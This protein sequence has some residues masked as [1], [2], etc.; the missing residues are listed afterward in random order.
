MFD[1]PL[2]KSVMT[3]KSIVDASQR[4]VSYQQC[5]ITLHIF[6]KIDHKVLF[7]NRNKKAPGTFNKQEKLLKLMN[8]CKDKSAF[9]LTAKEQGEVIFK[10]TEGNYA[11]NYD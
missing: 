5:S 2:R 3:Q 1:L 11:I 7:I 10:L 8:A 9:L 4:A 6:N